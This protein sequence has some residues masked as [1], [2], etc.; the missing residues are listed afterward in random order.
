MQQGAVCCPKGI[1][2][3]TAIFTLELCCLQQ[4]TCTLFWVDSAIIGIRPSVLWTLGVIFGMDFEIVVND[5]LFTVR[6]L[7]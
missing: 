2:C 6:L 7:V 1:I 5:E 4:N 3:D